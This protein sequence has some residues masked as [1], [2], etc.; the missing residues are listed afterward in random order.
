MLEDRS[1]RNR[2]EVAGDGERDLRA[3]LAGR[4]SAS[5]ERQHHHDRSDQSEDNPAVHD[6]VPF[7]EG[8]WLPITTDPERP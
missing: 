7:N 2:A 1:D 5:G 3:A 8:C 6:G 4:Q